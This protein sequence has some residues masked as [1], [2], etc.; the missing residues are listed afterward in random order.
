[1]NSDS[2]DTNGPAA[3]GFS[4]REI[5][6]LLA[7]LPLAAATEPASLVARAWEHL[8]QFAGDTAP[9]HTPRFF[10]PHEWRVVRLLADDIIP[11]MA[12]PA[13]QP[14]P[15]CPSSWTSSCWTNPRPGSQCEAAC[16]GSI[17]SRTDR[18]ACGLR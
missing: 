16:I 6:G 11:A 3:H 10:T 17:P 15:V 4:R 9:P 1:M 7:A 14:M 18:F 2:P 8:E 5:L 13:A 12:A